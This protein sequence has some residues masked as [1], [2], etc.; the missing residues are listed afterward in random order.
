MLVTTVETT[1]LSG[2]SAAVEVLRGEVV[3]ELV[4]VVTGGILAAALPIFLI[5]AFSL[6]KLVEEFRSVLLEEG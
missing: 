2:V 5:V 1:E 3:M 4:V 6:C